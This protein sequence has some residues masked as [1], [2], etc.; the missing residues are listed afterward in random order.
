MLLMDAKYCRGR[1]CCGKES[2]NYEKDDSFILHNM[3]FLDSLTTGT[4]NLKQTN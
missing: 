4:S 2:L 3:Y 1:L